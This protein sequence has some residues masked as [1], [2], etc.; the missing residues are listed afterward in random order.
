MGE[1]WSFMIFASSSYKMMKGVYDI[2]LVKILRY[3][4]NLNRDGK[5]ITT[6]C[7]TVTLLNLVSSIFGNE[8]L[9]FTFI[10][11]VSV[12][13][14]NPRQILW[15]KTEGLF[16]VSSPSFAIWCYLLI[17]P[18]FTA[19]ELCLQL[20]AIIG[21]FGNPVDMG[22]RESSVPHGP[23]KTYCTD[24]NTGCY[25]RLLWASFTCLEM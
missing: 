15:Y 19:L 12:L 21:G 10:C 9:L 25:R 17:C 11:D 2:W 5:I 1:A 7:Q 13:V 14:Y 24:F 16:H 3:Y 22:H 20:M 4:I 6:S 23:L 8:Q 18:D